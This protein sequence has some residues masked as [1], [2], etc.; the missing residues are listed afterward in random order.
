MRVLTESFSV[1]RRLLLFATTQEKDIRGM[2]AILLPQFD[3]V[4]FTRYLNNPRA[5]PPEELAAAAEDLTG[6]GYPVVADP[7]EA[8]R[9]MLGAA[10]PEDLVCVTGSFFIAAEIRQQ[11]RNLTEN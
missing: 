5:V 8:W 3:A 1:R 11:M 6:R 9:E 10:A 2:L 7:A 4:I